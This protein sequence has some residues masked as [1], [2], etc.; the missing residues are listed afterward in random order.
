MHRFSM[1]AC[2]DSDVPPVRDVC[3]RDVCMLVR[4]SSFAC[5]TGTSVLKSCWTQCSSCQY[6]SLR[7]VF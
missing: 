7:T 3:M 6:V 4:F 1:C 2:N 5:V